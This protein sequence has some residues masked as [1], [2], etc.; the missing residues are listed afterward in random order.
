MFAECSI[1]LESLGGVLKIP[2]TMPCGHLYCLDCATFWFN[3]GERGQ[4]CACGRV[5]N[6]DDIIR[7][8]TS[9]ECS[10]ASTQTAHGHP[11][12][13]EAIE[14][15]GMCTQALR[16]IDEEGAHADQALAAALS[17]YVLASVGP[18]MGH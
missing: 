5:F 11:R 4:K 18:T 17:R 13:R 7:L 10:T 6:G 16:E 3:Q 1:C 8:W 15:M 12:T 9:G 2:V 14:V